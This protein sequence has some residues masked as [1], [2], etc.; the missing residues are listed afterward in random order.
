MDAYKIEMQEIFEVDRTAAACLN[1]IADFS[2]IEEWDHTVIRSCKTSNGTLGVRSTF[3]I[4]LKFGVRKIPMQYKI[5]EFDFPNR[6]VLVGEADNF[7]AVDE[8]LVKS[9]SPN[10]S[11]VTWNAEITFKGGISKVLPYFESQIKK[12]GK[13]TIDGLKLALEDNFQPL[14][15]STKFKIA[16]RLVFPGMFLFTKHG[17]NRGKKNFNPISTSITDKHIV[18]TGAT[19]GLGL[20]AAEALAHRGA[21]LT[22]VARNKSKAEKVIQD[23][24]SKTG[25]NNITL[26]LADLSLLEDTKAL[27]ERLLA[28][29]KTID[30][31]INNA[32]AL[33]NERALTSEGIERSFALLL[34]CPYALTMDLLPLLKQSKDGRVVNVL[35][36]GMYAQKLKVHDLETEKGKYDGS[37]AYANAKRGLMIITEQLT[38]E[39]PGITFNAMHPGWADT[40]GVV[41]SLP[42]F[43]KVTKNVLRTPAQGADTI[44]WLAAAKEA[45]QVKG[46]F[47]LDRRPHT[48]HLISKTKSKLENRKLLRTKLEEYVGKLTMEKV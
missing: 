37:L 13:K 36:G 40:P 6:A 47:L 45:N 24:Q 44:V 28:K 1:Y 21:K 33:F 43:Y 12:N 20:A 39:H 38:E 2:L 34:L 14:S 31:L 46:K 27:A 29:N 41:E 18:L 25:N 7:I 42:G 22:L 15:Y 16:D 5:T 9:I 17:Y 10:R 3:E 48:T 26:E 8:V 11:K 32:G 30:V 23:I 19:S 35:S 4:I